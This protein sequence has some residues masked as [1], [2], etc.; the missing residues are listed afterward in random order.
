MKRLEEG[1]G[2][3]T[4]VSL[5]LRLTCLYQVQLLLQSHI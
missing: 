2:L 1:L 5:L 4:F 3:V